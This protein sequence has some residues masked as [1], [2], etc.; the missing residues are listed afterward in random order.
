MSPVTTEFEELQTGILQLRMF[1]R[2]YCTELV[3]RLR[4]QKWKSSTVAEVGGLSRIESVR[5]DI[6]FA[7]S[8]AGTQ[9]QDLIDATLAAAS[10]PALRSFNEYWGTSLTK[11]KNPQF[12]RYEPGHF[13]KSHTDDGAAFPKRVASVVTYLTD[14]YEGGE[15]RF[16]LLDFQFRPAA[17][18]AL[19]FPSDYAHEVLRIKN[20]AKFVFLFFVEAD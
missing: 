17:G 5:K 18:K 15:I 1:P 10:G 6:R 13:I 3:G 20:G 2:D 16:P 8:V 19:V 14:D 11:V 4:T 9:A 12:T 7:L